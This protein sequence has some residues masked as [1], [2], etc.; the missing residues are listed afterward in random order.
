[1]VIGS[2]CGFIELNTG[3][4]IIRILFCVYFLNEIFSDCLTN[5]F[6]HTST[7][8]HLYVSLVSF[9]RDCLTPDLSR[10]SR[11]FLIWRQN[12]YIALHYTMFKM[13]GCDMRFLLIF[14][15]WIWQSVYT[16]QIN[17]YCLS[18]PFSHRRCHYFLWNRS[19]DRLL[20]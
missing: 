13:V 14:L 16:K 1:M 9:L 2:L 19:K 5:Q 20:G 6:Q 12:I 3:N 11:L 18:Y 7:S 4:I 10:P 15:L 8:L 17:Y